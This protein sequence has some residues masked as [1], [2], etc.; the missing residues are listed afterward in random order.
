MRVLL[1]VGAGGA[2]TTTVAAATAVTAARAGI[3][4][5]L[6]STD[7]TSSLTDVLGLPVGE[8]PEVE[9]E[10]AREV[11]PGLAVLHADQRPQRA[12][13]AAARHAR[14]LPGALGVD[15]LS[16]PELLALPGAADV[17]ALWSLAE[18]VRSGPWD[19]VVADVTG[20]SA[21]LAAPDT[22]LQVLEGLWS[23]ER[24]LGQR[25]HR[26]DPFVLRAVA[27]LR[28][29]LSSVRDMLRAST[30]SVR[31]VLEP[32]ALG[33]VQARRTYTALTV[34]GHV[35]DGIV[36]NQVL[37]AGDGPDWL[38]SWAAVQAGVLADADHSF[39]PLPVCRLPRLPVGPVGPDALARLGLSLLHPGDRP[40]EPARPSTM[41]ERLLAAPG[42]AAG[43]R[44]HRTPDGYEL[45]LGVPFVGA[46]DIELARDG[47]QLRLRVQGARRL[48]E[49]PPVL[50]RCVATGAQVS[51]GCLVVRFRPDPGL[52]P[53]SGGRA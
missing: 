39:A 30:T 19:L 20:G 16:L 31:L 4:T 32:Q 47:D 7:R 1:L 28:E 45:V 25:R 37:P 35:V 12:L 21:T 38:T 24:L 18:Q 33:L 53:T 40:R 29:E 3:K 52:W 22:L 44:V 49:L 11:E 48:V 51:G 5:L 6:L 36:A 50:R 15:S 8:A 34:Q 17:A 14:H 46:R 26:L 2:G 41:V 43:P 9:P 10:V 42:T 23:A 27:R 13:S